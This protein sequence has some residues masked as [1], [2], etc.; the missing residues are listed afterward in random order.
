MSNRIVVSKTKKE[1]KFIFILVSWNNYDKKC[2]IFLQKKS[3]KRFCI[4]LYSQQLQK[5]LT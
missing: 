4:K 5:K 2:I 1:K 3:V